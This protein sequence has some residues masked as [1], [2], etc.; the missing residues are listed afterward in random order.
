VGV[1]SSDDGLKLAA[2]AYLS[3]IYTSTNGGID[4]T[5]G[6][7]GD[8]WAGL[9]G[10]ADGSHLVAAGALG[11]EVYTSANSGATWSAV[12]PYSG[13]S[14]WDAVTMSAN[15]SVM[16][17]GDNNNLFTSN[18]TGAV[19]TPTLAGSKK[20]RLAASDDGAIIVA[21]T[22]GGQIYISKNYGVSWTATATARNWLGVALS[23][24][25]VNIVAVERGNA[26]LSS[27]NVWRSVDSGDNWALL[28]NSPTKDWNAIASSS[29]GTKLA[30]VANPGQI[31][32]SSDS[33]ASWAAVF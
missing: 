22:L 16:V 9:A 19:W 29:S 1:S 32:T 25:G 17:A 26:S 7:T 13:T 3:G 12:F 20:W 8:N 30:A 2:A 28:P 4:W 33:G 11:S 23:A 27:G 31:Y 10:S 21:T 14:N 18:D 5:A 15:A 6:A 24:S